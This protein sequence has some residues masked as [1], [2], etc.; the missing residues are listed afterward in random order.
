MGETS[1]NMACLLVLFATIAL[2]A[3]PITA[4]PTAAA[5]EWTKLADGPYSAREGLM[6]VVTTSG[7][8]V[9]AGGR[10]FFG[11]T[12]TAD[13]WASDNGTEWKQLPTVPW[14]GRAYHAMMEFKGCFHRKPVLQRCLEELRRRT[15][16]AEPRERTL[17]DQGWDCVHSI[18]RQDVRGWRLLPL[19]HRRWPILSQ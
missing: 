17:G 10:K 8:I 7:K 2:N 5:S 1:G 16:L 9:M 6:A 15:E 14:K 11:A 3:A 18:Q 13:A 4:F 12:V 19:Q